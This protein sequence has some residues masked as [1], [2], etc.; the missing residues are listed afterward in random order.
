[1]KLSYDDIYASYNHQRY[2]HFRN[3][4]SGQYKLEDFKPSKSGSRMQPILQR[5]EVSFDEVKNLN[6][7][8]YGSVAP[9]LDTEDFTI[10]SNYLVDFWGAIMGNCAVDAYMHLKRHAYGKKDYC[11]IDIG[12]IALKMKRSKNTVK[13]YLD[14][15]EE[16][17]FI[18]IFHRIDKENNNRDVS[19]LFKIRRYVPLITEEMYNGLDPKLKS[20]H[21][22]FMKN[23][24]NVNFAK[25]TYDTS[26][27][28]KGILASG[29][30][31]NSKGVQRKIDQSIKEGTT[32][33]F[34]LDTLA[35]EQKLDNK[36]V[37][38]KISES[39]SK[40][41][42]DTWIR[43]VIVFKYEDMAIVLSPNDEISSFME[44]NYTDYL[45]NLFVC[46]SVVFN[47]HE[48]YIENHSRASI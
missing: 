21:D 37:H 8:S 6:L 42:Y 36:V 28:I 31:I 48:E 13:G 25:Q 11:Y 20:L 29:K 3:K 33:N 24:E 10:I 35:D 39:V 40:P 15:L 9:T 34:I 4:S 45:S 2:A 26:T 30:I 43:N 38:K 22:S 12:L 14:T 41:T 47:S 1:M 32:R 46:K 23:F 5:V 17:G 7:D 44:Y 19:P 16:Y 18:A 27:L